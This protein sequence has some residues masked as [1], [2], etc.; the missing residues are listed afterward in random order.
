METRFGNTCQLEMFLIYSYE[1]FLADIDGSG[2]TL[3]MK[4]D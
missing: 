4:V 2:Q 3:L 1:H